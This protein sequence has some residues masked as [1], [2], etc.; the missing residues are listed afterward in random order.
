V[1]KRGPKQPTKSE[2]FAAVRP[3]A[4]FWLAASF[5]F[6]AGTGNPYYIWK[7]IEVCIAY[8]KDF[9]DWVIAYFS[10]CIE[11][12]KSDRAKKSGDLREVLPWVFGFPNLLE[13]TQRKRGPGKLLNPNDGPPIQIF[14]LRFWRW[15]E[16]GEDPLEAMHN[17]C[18]DVFDGKTADRVKDKTLRSWLLREFDLI[19]WPSTAEKWKTIA[20]E[21]YCSFA[22][23]LLEHRR[24][25]V[26]G[27]PHFGG[28]VRFLKSKGLSDSDIGRACRIANEAR[29]KPALLIQGKESRETRS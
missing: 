9:P 25:L 13:P 5:A 18:N 17:A 8:K 6:F 27:V 4:N 29:D 20:R 3:D 28:F 14:A 22:E 26:W 11:R 16:R 2:I 15:L 10:D 24:Q 7:A 23:S 1:K 21:R 12:M 19:E